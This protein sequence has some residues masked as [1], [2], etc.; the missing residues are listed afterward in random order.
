MTIMTVMTP[1]V[2]DD[3]ESTLLGF[4]KLQP[5]EVLLQEMI[6]LTSCEIQQY[7]SWLKNVFNLYAT[8]I[9]S[10][11]V[12][13]QLS[14]RSH[15]WYMEWIQKHRFP[16]HVTHLPHG[17]QTGRD[18]C[19]SPFRHVHIAWD[20]SVG[21]CTDFSDFSVGNVRRTDLVE[22]FHSEAARSFSQE[23]RYGNCITCEHC[24]WRNSK[25]F[26]F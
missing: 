4:A 7:Q 26:R 16:F 17:V 5:D 9:T 19:L 12:Q 24:S 8:D 18:Y 21:F 15:E 11:Q 20:G 10:W 23:I 14:H 6:V 25:S 3:L 13:E 22:L 2:I 1:P